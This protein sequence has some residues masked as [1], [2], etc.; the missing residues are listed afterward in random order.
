VSALIALAMQLF[1]ALLPALIESCTEKQLKK[2][3][4]ELPPANTFASEGEA[5]AAVFDKAIANLPKF[6]HRRRKGLT[7]MKQKAIQGDKIR[8]KPLTA[9]ELKEGKKLVKGIRV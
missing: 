4:K 7:R 8:T 5:L 9:A 1:S 6:A 3:A 2:A